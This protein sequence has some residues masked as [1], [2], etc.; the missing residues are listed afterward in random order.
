MQERN[1][2][3]RL[4]RQRISRRRLLG[5]AAAVGVGAAGIALVGC[6]NGNGGP[7]ITATDTPAGPGATATPMLTRG[8]IYRNFSFDAL[9]IDTLDPHQT[10]FGPTYNMHSAVFSKVLQYD[11]EVEQVMSPDL[12]VSM[13]ESPDGLEWVITIRD[14]VTFHDTAEIQANFPDVAG[15]KL[16]AED[17]KFSIE[18]QIDAS[19]PQRDLYYRKGHWSAIERIEVVD[20]H[21]LKI[22]TN[23]PLAPFLH[24]LAARNAYIV[25]K[26][27]VDDGDE[28]NDPTRM[29]G[30]GPFMLKEITAI[31][32]VSVRR[33]PNW[34]AKDDNPGGVGLDRPF[35]DGYD[36]IWTPQSDQVQEA[37]LKAKEVDSSGMDDDNNTLRIEEDVAGIVLGE[38]GNTGTIGMRLLVDRPPFNDPR[39]RRAIHLALDRR[40]LGEQMFP[41]AP[42]RVGFLSAGPVAWPLTEWA[43]PRAELDALPGYRSSPAEREEDIAEA[44]RLWQAGD[45][46]SSVDGLGANIPTYIPNAGTPEMVRE[47]SENLGL[48]WNVST[49]AYVDLA[50]CLLRNQQDAAEGTC[51]YAFGFNNGWIDLDDWVYPFL[52]ST[53]SKNASR[54]SDPALDAMLDEQRQEFDAEQRQQLGHQIQRYLL[55]E[56]NDGLGVHAAIPLINNI[57]RALYWSYI[58]NRFQPQT[59][60]GQNFLYANLW[61]DQDDP[62]Y[63]GRPA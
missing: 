3:N 62:N 50:Q 55:E 17:I 22:V 6:G 44:R 61:L 8:G 12:A 54:L 16:T 5:G 29:V 53:G 52:H 48:D 43:L 11:N 36:S 33:N 23:V 19:S 31:Q 49:V 13:P 37:A 34:F 24:Y 4:Q 20:D 10:Q 45:G 51:F 21:T 1:Y 60:F 18:R 30:T 15:R 47:L 46:P 57:T 14:N 59:W 9:T 42:G 38:I 39:L 7:V 27:L 58:K 28:M 63:A 26:E 56:A 32:I 41:S 35:L 2:W 25:A 40:L